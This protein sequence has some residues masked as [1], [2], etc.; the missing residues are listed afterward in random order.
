MRS[1]IVAVL[2][3]FMATA[4]LAQ[5]E[6]PDAPKDMPDNGGAPYVTFAHSYFKDAPHV[7]GLDDRLSIHVRNFKTLLKSVNGNCQGI[8]LFLDGMPI[9]G[10]RAESC[11][12]EAGHIRY[13]LLR[14]KDDEQA[15][16]TLL[17]SPQGYTREVPV[18]VGSDAQVSLSS[19]ATLKLEVIPRPQ[20]LAFLALFALSLA[21]FIHLCR[22]TSLVRSGTHPVPN[23]RPYSLSLFQMSFWFFLVIAAYVFMWL[24]TDELD[25]IT[26]S[27]L[28][29]IGIGAATALGAAL[30]DKNK[31]APK[32][33]EPGGTSKGFLNDVMSDPTGVSLHRFQ[34]FVWTIVLGVIF[35]GSVYKSLEMPEFSATLLGLMGISSGTYL[36]FKVPE[37]QGSDTPPGATTPSPEPDPTETPAT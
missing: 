23:E 7:A 20:F 33:D 3:L 12:T 21:I 6:P 22:K 4:V 19:N 13:R 17:G 1:T 30:I 14:T 32:P 34:M 8:I 9:K 5:W 15:W 16:H 35:I 28:G 29:L 37:K 31:A 26:D 27:V 36:G 10:D 24:I 18:S 11:D 25:T 2:S